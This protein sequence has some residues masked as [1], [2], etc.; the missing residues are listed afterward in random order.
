MTFKLP[1]IRWSRAALVSIA[2]FA[3]A[4]PGWG[5]AALD[6]IKQTGTVTIAYRT[7]TVP[8]SYTIE[9]GK[10]I[11]YAIDL[12]Q[13]FVQAIGRATGAK[14]LE[15][16][17]VP[18]T[19]KTRIPTIVEG[20]ADLE[21]VSTTNTTERRKLVAF[22]IPHYVTGARFAV[23]ADS[24]I[25][26]L[27]DFRNRKLVSTT[28]TSPLKAVRA[29]NSQYLIGAQI[30]EVPDHAAGLETVDAGKADGFVMDEVLLAGLNASRPDPSRLKIV[31]KYLTIEALGIMMPR[32]DLE[33]LKIVNDEMRRLIYSGEAAALHDRWFVEPIPPKNRSLGVPMPHLLRDFWRYPSERVP[34]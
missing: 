24:D 17:Y 28:E 22:S 13:R 29:A 21:C 11:G 4:S 6:R 32:D 30:G 8:F 14:K 18:V 20:K 7:A 9:E 12:C 16:K 10:P 31:G 27:A 1:F 34:E 26:A 5:G 23:R 15:V 2:L 19:T 33:L 3:A 25:T